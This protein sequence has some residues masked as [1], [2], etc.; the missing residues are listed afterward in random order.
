MTE[1]LSYT[2]YD[3]SIDLKFQNNIVKPIICVP[4]LHKEEQRVEGCI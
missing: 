2:E 1:P 3:D 4:I